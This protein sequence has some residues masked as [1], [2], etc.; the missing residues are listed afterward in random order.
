MNAATKLFNIIN[1]V[2]L[3]SKKQVQV[4]VKRLLKGGFWASQG[5]IKYGRFFII[6]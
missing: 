2:V 5:Q 1:S 4:I 3:H 6:K